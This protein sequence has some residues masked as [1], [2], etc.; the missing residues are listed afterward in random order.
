MESFAAVKLWGRSIEKKMRY[1]VFVG[2]GD[3]AAHKAV[4]SMNDGSG[5]YGANYPVIKEECLN[6]VSKRLGTRL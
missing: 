6:H 1:V 3:C 4:C 2:D 5:P